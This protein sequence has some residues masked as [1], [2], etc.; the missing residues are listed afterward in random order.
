MAKNPSK[1]KALAPAGQRKSPTSR[2]AVAPVAVPATNDNLLQILPSPIAVA[3]LVGTGG[4]VMREQTV[5]LVTGRDY[6]TRELIIPAEEIYYDAEA[7]PRGDGP[8]IGEADK[9]AWRDVASGY[10][11][12][13]HRDTHRG[14]L[15]GYVGIPSDHPLWG[16]HKQAV[17][18][19][20][21]I[22][23]HGGLSYGAIC[24]DGPSPARRLIR[25][26]HR[27]CHVPPTP[28]RYSAIN[29]ATD[30]KVEDSHAWWF[31]FNCYH[32][33]DLVPGDPAPRSGSMQAEIGSQ[34]RDDSYVLRETL[35]LAAQLR[36]IADGKSAPARE[37]LLPPPIGLDPD[38]GGRV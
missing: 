15:S 5:T 13:I 17:P 31:G 21:G 16:W 11:C 38:R 32:A 36:A 19:D 27:I 34:Y 20:L 25:E 33:Y 12:I 24:Q 35:A 2:T 37:G 9:I 1:S 23:V 4:E 30:Y 18:P 10:D 7:R 14:F 22:H 29:H 3:K 28:P 6:A 26:A 8:W